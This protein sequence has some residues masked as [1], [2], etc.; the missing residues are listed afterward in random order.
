MSWVLREGVE[1]HLIGMPGR[2]GRAG[3]KG[4]LAK[5]RHQK[6]LPGWPGQRAKKHLRSG[7]P[8]GSNNEGQVQV[9]SLIDKRAVNSWKGAEVTGEILAGGAFL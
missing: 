5:V 1:F 2:K 6:N 4:S 8:R 7:H 3:R 9:L